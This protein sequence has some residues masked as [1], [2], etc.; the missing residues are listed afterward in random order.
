MLVNITKS[1]FIIKREKN[2]ILPIFIISSKF[3]Y[4]L[5]L[6]LSLNNTNYNSPSENY[7]PYLTHTNSA[8]V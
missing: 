6:S 4:Y 3:N 1:F 5:Y 8:Y 2:V 7:F